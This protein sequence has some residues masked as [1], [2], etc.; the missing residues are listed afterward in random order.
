MRILRFAVVLR[1]DGFFHLDDRKVKAVYP[2]EGYVVMA[3]LKPSP[4]DEDFG[5]PVLVLSCDELLEIQRKMRE[6][7]E[8][9]HKLLGHGWN[10]ARPFWKLQDFL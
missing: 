9:T 7:D 8:L 5:F 4:I 6:S 10:G 3:F 2:G 1:K